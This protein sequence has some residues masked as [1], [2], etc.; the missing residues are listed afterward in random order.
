LYG[1]SIFTTSIIGIKDLTST[2]KKQKIRSI[3]RQKEAVSDDIRLGSSYLMEFPTKS[4]P[5][6]FYF[7][8]R[9]VA[10]VILCNFK[11]NRLQFMFIFKSKL[12][13]SF[14]VSSKMVLVLL[15]KHS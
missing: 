15:T 5:I 7:H 8:I 12:F 1:K 13:Q 4:L 11:P 2:R 9:V 14:L 6:C 3:F 10:E